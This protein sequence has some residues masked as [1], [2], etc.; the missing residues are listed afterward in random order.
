[1]D[2]LLSGV[3]TVSD[4]NMSRHLAMLVDAEGI[5]VE[6]SGAAGVSGVLRVLAESGDYLTA[7]QIEDKMSQATHIIWATGGDMVPEEERKA[8]YQ[9][10][11]AL[12]S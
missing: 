11:Q 9:K 6:P 3:Y 12:L 10:G 7:H 4:D 8:Y 1:M 2:S 5:P